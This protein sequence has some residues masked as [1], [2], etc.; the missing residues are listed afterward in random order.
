MSD[1]YLCEHKEQCCGTCIRA[2]KTE[3][4]RVESLLAQEQARSERYKAALEKIAGYHGDEECFC[5]SYRTA[6]SA[7]RP[8]SEGGGKS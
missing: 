8:P 5:G 2:T 7:L 4:N 6:K 1:Y 3:L